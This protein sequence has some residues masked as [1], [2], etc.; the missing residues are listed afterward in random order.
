MLPNNIILL[1]II[2]KFENNL[3]LVNANIFKPY[4]YMESEVQEQKQHMQKYC[5][6]SANG[7]QAKFFDTQE[8]NEDYKIQKPQMQNIHDE[9]K[10]KI[11]PST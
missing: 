10:W 9:K 7:V 4:K 3:V 1:V 5:E 2:E 6:Q 11:L 8:E